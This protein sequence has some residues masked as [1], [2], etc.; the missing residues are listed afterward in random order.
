MSSCTCPLCKREFDDSIDVCPICGYQYKFMVSIQR[1]DERIYTD[2]FFE[3]IKIHDKYT[4]IKAIGV[5]E[6]L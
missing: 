6:Y 5:L 2:L 3:F 4:T 1:N